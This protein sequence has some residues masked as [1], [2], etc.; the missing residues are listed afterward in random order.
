MLGEEN[1]SAMMFHWWKGRLDWVESESLLTE[2]DA[3]HDTRHRQTCST[4]NDDDVAGASASAASSPRSGSH[5]R[6]TK[7]GMAGVG[8]G[9]RQVVDDAEGE[10]EAAIRA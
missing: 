3:T 4:L 7:G 8:C 6:G 5:R 9:A 2:F 1:A 10:E